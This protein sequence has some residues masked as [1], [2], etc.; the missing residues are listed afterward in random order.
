M[1]LLDL[2]LSERIPGAQEFLTQSA[3]ALNQRAG[4]VVKLCKSGPTTFEKA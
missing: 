1:V 2:A 3:P 4:W